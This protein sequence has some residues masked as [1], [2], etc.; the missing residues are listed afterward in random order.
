MLEKKSNYLY[1]VFHI[2][3]RADTILLVEKIRSLFLN[4]IHVPPFSKIGFKLPS[5][6][7]SSPIFVEINSALNRKSI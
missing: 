2:S 1:A 6:R 5:Y 3:M 4:I 7:I